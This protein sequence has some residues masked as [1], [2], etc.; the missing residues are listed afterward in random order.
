V[1]TAT[2]VGVGSVIQR[3]EGIPRKVHGELEREIQKQALAVLDLAKA[4]V[5]GPVL[6]NRTG[7]LRR[8]INMQMDVGA[9]RIVGAVGIK[10]SYAPAH[11]FGF[12]G[13]VLVRAHVRR[14]LQQMKEDQ[15]SRI[16]GRGERR[17]RVVTDSKKQLG[18]GVIQ[19]G[20]HT[21]EMDLPERSFLR[22]ALDERRQ[23]I[24]T[25]IRDAMERGVGR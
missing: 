4:K 25:G 2:V 23:A 9:G 11:E 7:T 8:K 22:S 24:L 19:V 21:R 5:S 20:E 6:R 10:L 18:A 13:A 17:H 12:Q 1:L 14:S 15:R 3:L 16:V